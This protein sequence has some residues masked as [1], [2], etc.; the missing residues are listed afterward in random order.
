MDARHLGRRHVDGHGRSSRAD[1]DENDR[2]SGLPRQSPDLVEFLA[3]GVGRAD[4][5]DV[6]IRHL[7][8]PYRAETSIHPRP[9]AVSNLSESTEAAGFAP[10]MRDRLTALTLHQNAGACRS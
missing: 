6:P 10:G 3:Y 9:P 7:Q 1:V 4:D 5:V 8:S 2:G